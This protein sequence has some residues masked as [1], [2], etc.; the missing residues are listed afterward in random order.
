MY[1]QVL[2]G[3]SYIERRY[4]PDCCMLSLLRCVCCDPLGKALSKSLRTAY[5]TVCRCVSAWVHIQGCPPSGAGSFC[6]Q[7]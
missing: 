5:K 2:A 3:I 1:Q 4:K 6:F 7:F